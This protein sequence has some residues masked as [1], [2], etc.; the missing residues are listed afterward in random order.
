MKKVEKVNALKASEIKTIAENYAVSVS[1]YPQDKG[2]TFDTATYKAYY[3]GF[4][5]AMRY[6]NHNLRKELTP[7]T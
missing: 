3:Q 2:R 4:R 5:D 7:E 6:F 1:P